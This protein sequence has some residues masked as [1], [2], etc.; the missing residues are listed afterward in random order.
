[1]RAG[2]AQGGRSFRENEVF[3][4]SDN[5]QLCAKTFFF[6]EFDAM[7]MGKDT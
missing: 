1:M 5:N 7:I 3:V 4:Q 6:H 2:W